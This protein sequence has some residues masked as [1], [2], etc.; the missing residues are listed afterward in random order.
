MADLIE[1]NMHQF[2]N[3]LETLTLSPLPLQSPSLSH[4]D[5]SRQ[6]LLVTIIYIKIRNVFC[7]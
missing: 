4:R 3:F 7:T 2:S 5:Y 1:I 6:L